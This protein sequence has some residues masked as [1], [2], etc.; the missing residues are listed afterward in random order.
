MYT[1]RGIAFFSILALICG[2]MVTVKY[3]DSGSEYA[4]RI[5]DVEWY[6]SSSLSIRHGG[7]VWSSSNVD[8]YLLV[9]SGGKDD[10]GV[11][12]IGSFSRKR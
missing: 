4:L 2:Q 8:K 6:R 12:S 3:G 11:S 7:Q 1:F 5:N 10:T 9:P